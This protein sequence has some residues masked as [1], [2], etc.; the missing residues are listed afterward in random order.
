MKSNKSTVVSVFCVLFLTIT[1]LG[2]GEISV[3]KSVSR[4][5][6]Y[7][8]DTIIVSI[9]VKNTGTIDITNI[10]VLDS[11][12]SSFLTNYLAKVE[13]PLLKPGES[14]N[15]SYMMISVD[16][17]PYPTSI[18]F[19]PAE[20][21]YTY[22][23]TTW[24]AESNP[25][26]I[27]LNPPRPK[28]PRLI[29]TKTLSNGSIEQHSNLDVTI[30][31]SNEGRTDAVNVSVS[32][33]VPLGLATYGNSSAFYPEIKPGNVVFLQYSINAQ[34]AGNFVSNAKITYKDPSG[35]TYAGASNYVTF[36]VTPKAIMAEPET[37]FLEKIG[38]GEKF[39]GTSLI[40]P[41]IVIIT[42]AAALLFA[43]YFARK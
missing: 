5:Q 29:I 23:S 10:T 1:A 8:G 39:S 28:Q 3:Q 14:K 40:L 4:T 42:T 33:Y 24:S 11:E 22:N 27:F 25:T 32:D 18:V 6:V 9:F 13:Y 20:V 37:S 2:Y 19:N 35:E 16:S 30:T 38:L 43:L 41:I 21:T 15:Y 7:E 34:T 26:V 31:I 36:T 17:A 12:L